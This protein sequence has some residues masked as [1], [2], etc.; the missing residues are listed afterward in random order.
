M[1][2]LGVLVTA[3]YL[4]AA[5]SPVEDM[6]QV[7]LQDLLRDSPADVVE[8]ARRVDGCRS[9]SAEDVT[10]EASD[11]RVERAIV[12]LRCDELV[13][14]TATLRRK[15]VQLERTVRAIDLLRALLR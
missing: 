14:D 4:H 1:R 10:D 2:F 8:L 7:V 12:I 13:E 9:L 5:S 6:G 3:A 15:Y 11:A